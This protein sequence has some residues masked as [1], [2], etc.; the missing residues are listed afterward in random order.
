MV[1]PQVDGLLR[2]SVLPLFHGDDAGAEL[3]NHSLQAVDNEV[4]SGLFSISVPRYVLELR[5]QVSGLLLG[6]TERSYNVK[7]R[8]GI[9]QSRGHQLA[10]LGPYYLQL[11]DIVLNYLQASLDGR[12]PG[13]DGWN[14]QRPL[15]RDASR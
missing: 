5:L 10:S 12:D 7:R 6:G 1:C 2:V 9:T 3:R 4:V 13:V 11:C 14:E 15:C 8:R